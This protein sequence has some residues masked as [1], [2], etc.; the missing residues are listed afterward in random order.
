[1]LVPNRH[2]S[3]DAYRYGFIGME[4]DDELKGEGNSYDFGARMLDVRIG[5]WFAKDPLQGSYPHL[6]PYNFVANSPLVYVDKDGKKIIIYYKNY[7][8]KEIAFEYKPGIKPPNNKYVQNTVKM[9]DKLLEVEALKNIEIEGSTNPGDRLT[10][11]IKSDKILHMIEIFGKEKNSSAYF[12]D[13]Y[14]P[15]TFKPKEGKFGEFEDN[16]GFGTIKVND[17]FGI[18]FLING[19]VFTNSPTSQFGHEIIHAIH[20]NECPVET[21]DRRDT[22]DVP[23]IGNKEEEITTKE[24]NQINDKLKEPRRED[25]SG[26]MVKMDNPTVN[27]K[28]NTS[29]TTTPT[30]ANK[31]SKR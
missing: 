3:T 30:P 29:S 7:Q 10:D 26:T 6:S 19:K 18:E 16:G 22:K 2:S 21:Q 24:A 20:E 25:Y 31:T 15:G 1:M 9:L 28:A 17:E 27:K 14:V 8:G 11:I 13:D 12:K 23:G 5:R 4:K